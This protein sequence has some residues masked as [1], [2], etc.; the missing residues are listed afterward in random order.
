M[1]LELNQGTKPEGLEVRSR[2]MGS[3]DDIVFIGEYEISLKD[4]FATVEYVLT[5]SDL[6]PNDP[7]LQFVERIRSMKEVEGYDKGR[8]HLEALTQPLVRTIFGV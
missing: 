5:N 7:R 1:S 8:K 4:F 6:E 3:P 2:N